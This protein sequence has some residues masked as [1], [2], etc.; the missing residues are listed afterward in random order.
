MATVDNNQNR[1]RRDSFME[2]MKGKHADQEYADDESLFGQISDD[3]DDY[4]KKIADYQGREK[5]MSD[6]FSSDPRSAAYLMSW[7]NG[8]DPAVELVR[9]FGTDIKDAIDDPARQEEMAAA[10]KEFLD[11]VTKEKKLKEE[12]EKNLQASL[13]TIEQMQQKN[14]LS[15]EQVDAAM[16]LL[17]GIVKDG[18]MG[19][20]TS[21]SIEMAMKAINHDADVTTANHEGVV[22]GKNTRVKEQ[23][24]KPKQGDGQPQMGSQNGA[25]MERPK[26]KSIFDLAAEAN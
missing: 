14:G 9:Q 26:Q 15:D 22:Q 20:F 2:R 11:R 23:L 5:Q 12:Y 3:Y 7:K 17:M 24:R 4:D 1:S 8:G 10:N 18:V 21:E 19:K 16:E 25:A 13:T 6:M